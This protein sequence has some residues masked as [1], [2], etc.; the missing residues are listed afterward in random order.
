MPRLPAS[1]SPTT[2]QGR[3]LVLLVTLVAATPVVLALAVSL[4]AV[5]LPVGEVWSSVLAHTAAGLG[6]SEPRTGVND[7]IIWQVRVPRVLL[8]F[9]VGAGLAVAGATLQAVVRNP[10]ADPYVLGVSSGAGL[11]AVAAL[12][13]GGAGWPA[14]LGVSGAAFAGGLLT[15]G[16]VLV[17]GRNGGRVDPG[18]L[19]LAGVA[20]GYLLQAATSYLQLRVSSNQLAHL[21]FWLLGTVSGADWQKLGLPAAV[22]GV[23]TGWLVLRGR[24]LNALLLGDDLAASA[25]VAVSRLRTELLVVTALL[26]GAVIA[27]AGGVQF[28]GLVA[29]HCVR[30]IVGA[31]HRRLLPLSALLGGNFLVLADLAARTVSMPLE[32]P[33]TVVT[34][35]VGV[36]FFLVLL[37]RG[38]PAG[39]P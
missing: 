9:V 6:G 16:A 22:V 27:V 12:T 34:A 4:G 20:L 13:L 28:V 39:T 29:P 11:A 23:C 17:L 37:R 24:A 32:L 36:P 26:T 31:D 19:L 14:R 2:G 15:L 3:F 1:R 18:R 5:R 33:L 10:L 8:G 30:L 21:L 38:T 35:V 7:Q 25:G